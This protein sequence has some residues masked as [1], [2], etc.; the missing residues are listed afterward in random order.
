MFY[1]ITVKY[2]L[3]V[4]FFHPWHLFHTSTIYDTSCL[5]YFPQNIEVINLRECM[6]NSYNKILTTTGKKLVIYKLTEDWTYLAI[7][8]F[9]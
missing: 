4:L 6:D 9:F 5:G 7:L 1:L 3:L 8:N 2:V